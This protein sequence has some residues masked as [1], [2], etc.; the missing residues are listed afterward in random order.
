MAT[1]TQGPLLPGGIHLGGLN[2]YTNVQ[3]G[4]TAPV[5]MGSDVAVSTAG[6]YVSSIFIPRRVTIE[7]FGY[8]VGSVSGVGSVQMAMWNTAG[9]IAIGT[10]PSNG[11]VV[12][13]ANTYQEL[14]CNT[15]FNV[16]G[17]GVYWL[18]CVF[19]DARARVKMIPNANYKTPLTKFYS[20]ASWNGTTFSLPN[21]RPSGIPTTFASDVGPFVYALQE[22]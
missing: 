8:L 15:A 16:Q 4:D 20:T 1:T 21:L 14:T 6:L 9:T 2:C 22:T 3:L 17:P 10:T 11:V 18:G 13:T 12:G 19:S 5:A 7:K